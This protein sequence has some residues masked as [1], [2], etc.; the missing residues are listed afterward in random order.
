MQIRELDA[1][2]RL[3]TANLA[4]FGPSLGEYLKKTAG[5]NAQIAA[6]IKQMKAENQKLSAAVR[7]ILD[8]VRNP[9]P[10]V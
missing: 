6:D 10:P 9:R 1:V 7:E 8:A 3:N 5:H 4:K 2:T